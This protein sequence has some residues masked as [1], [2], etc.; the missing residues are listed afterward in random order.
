[1]VSLRD[2]MRQSAAC[3]PPRGGARR[4][5]ASTR[6]CA[7]GARLWPALAH[8]LHGRNAPLLVGLSGLPGSGKSTLAA[9]LVDEARRHG[10]EAQRLSLDDFYLGRATRRRLARDVHPLLLTRGV[11]GTHDLPLLRDTLRALARASAR[12]P[13]RLPRFDK[14]RDT[15]QPP[16][17]WP[18]VTRPPRLVILEGWCLGMPPQTTAQL[19]RPVNALERHADADGRWR[20]HVN[21]QLRRYQ[22]L[23]QAP[24][25]RI[26]LH[27]PGFACARRW[28]AGAE[29]TLRRRALPQA[30]SSR[31]LARFLDHYQRLGTHAQRTLDAWADLRVD[32]DGARRVRAIR[33]LRPSQPVGS[34]TTAVP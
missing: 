7:L 33:R 3:G 32:L 25:L 29:R 8:T 18:R 4:R 9:A 10:V 21:A 26:W 1:M 12:R 24:A 20:L 22:P 16:S 15:R 27:A 30:L 31:A 5:D 19:Q 6:A 11:P 14:G 34:T 23:W 17:R 13:V 2:S 28:R